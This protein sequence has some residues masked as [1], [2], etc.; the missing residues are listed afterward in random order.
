MGGGLGSFVNSLASAAISDCL[1]G[2]GKFGTCTWE[3]FIQL[4]LDPWD[5]WFSNLFK[6]RPKVGIDSATDSDALFLLGSINPVVRLWGLGIRELEALGIP[7]SASGIGQTAYVSLAANAQADLERQFGQAQGSNLF[8][9]YAALIL[10]CT[11]PASNAACIATRET[12]DQQYQQAVNAKTID[13]QTGFP[14]LPPTVIRVPTCLPG[15]HPVGQVCRACSYDPTVNP[16]APSIPPPPQCPTG[17]QF[18]PATEKCTAPPPPPPPQCPPNTVGRYP[19]C[20]PIS[21][22]PV[23]PAGCNWV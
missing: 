2:E 8:A 22:Q 18:D 20:K 11:N 21:V 23:P 13:P 5:L 9:Q 10:H 12:L 19:V 1:L 3:S 6:G 15:Q 4:L 14:I 7:I 16:C 17:T